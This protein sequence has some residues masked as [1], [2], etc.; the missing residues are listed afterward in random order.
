LGIGSLKRD[1]GTGPGMCGVVEWMIFVGRMV[2]CSFI[3]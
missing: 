3:I 1:I 2:K